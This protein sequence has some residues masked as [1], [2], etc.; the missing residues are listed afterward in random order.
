MS[1]ADTHEGQCGIF[2]VVFF[3]H[4]YELQKDL[5]KQEVVNVIVQQS[6]SK[7]FLPYGMRV[8]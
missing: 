6:Q 3:G 4:K 8:A 7:C 5:L 2:A 1:F